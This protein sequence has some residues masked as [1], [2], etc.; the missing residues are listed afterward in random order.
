MKTVTIR[1]WIRLP[2]PQQ[3]DGAVLI[4][5][6]DDVSKIDA[7]SVGI[8]E[9]V[10]DPVRGL[11]DRI[12][13]CLT[14]EASLLTRGSYVLTAEIRHAGRALTRGDF[15]TTAAFPWAVGDRDDQVIDVTPI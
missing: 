11:C 10:I 4:V 13:F 3:F 15:L 14:A 1:G 9:T 7:L 6:L 5:G 12:P 2:S 8:A